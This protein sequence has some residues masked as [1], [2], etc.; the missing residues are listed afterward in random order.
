VGREQE[1]GTMLGQAESGTV[2]TGEARVG[3]AFALVESNWACLLKN[4][5]AHLTF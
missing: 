1:F 4:T 3:I 2:V 5:N